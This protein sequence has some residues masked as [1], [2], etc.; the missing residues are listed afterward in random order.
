MTKREAMK[1]LSAK[2]KCMIREVSGTDPE[3]NQRKCNDCSLCYAQGN[4][5]EQKEALRIAVEALCW[6]IRNGNDTI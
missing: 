1:L 4:M 6:D 3:C 2:L 5:G